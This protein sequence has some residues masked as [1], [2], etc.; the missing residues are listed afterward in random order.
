MAG[1]VCSGG[2]LDTQLSTH[3]ADSNECRSGG[4]SSQELDKREEK[5]GMYPRLSALARLNHFAVTEL[6]GSDESYKPSPLKN[7][8]MHDL[9][10]PAYSFGV[11][12]PPKAIH[13]L[14]RGE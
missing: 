5:V 7:T 10:N 13:G 8:R 4:F 3:W 2:I 12:G 1:C 11:K 14:S 6:R 9:T